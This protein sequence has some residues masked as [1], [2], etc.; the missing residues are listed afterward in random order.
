MGVILLLLLSRPS[1]SVR[2]LAS[3]GCGFHFYLGNVFVFFLFAAA[4]GL[5]GAA[6][7]GCCRSFS[8]YGVICW[9]G[10][11]SGC[12]GVYLGWW[13]VGRGVCGGRVGLRLLLRGF[14]LV[15]PGCDLPVAA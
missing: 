12:L 6:V 13:P 5:C 11:L 14:W 15:W 9:W 3:C 8:A 2:G 7:G 1:G 4:G 10:G